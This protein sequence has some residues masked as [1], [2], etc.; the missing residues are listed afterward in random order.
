[1]SDSVFVDTNVLVCARDAAVPEKQEQA[2]TWIEHL[3]RTRTGRISYQVL[4]EYYVTVTAKLQ[5]GMAPAEGRSDVRAL[6]AWA[7]AAPSPERL[8]AAWHLQDQF[9]VSWWDAQIIAAAQQSGCSV[10]LTEDLQHG[11]RFGDVQ[12][13]SPFLSL[14]E[15]VRNAERPL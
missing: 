5:P 2:A 12:V 8:N 13:R 7:P 9:S 6:L 3:W 4:H 11:Q 15:E 14:P 1:M 10:L